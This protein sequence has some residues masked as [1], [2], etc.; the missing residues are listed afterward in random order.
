MP[1]VTRDMVM[2][3]LPQP[4][5][6]VVVRRIGR[7]EV[8]HDALPQCLELTDNA[9]RLVNDVIVEHEMEPLRSSVSVAEELEELGERNMSIV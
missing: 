9:T 5:N 1:V 3:L 6:D 8:E 4:L 2:K 7:Q